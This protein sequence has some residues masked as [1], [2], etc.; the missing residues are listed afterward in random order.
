MLAKIKS[1]FSTPA[2]PLAPYSDGASGALLTCLL[3][4]AGFVDKTATGRIRVG[5]GMATP[6]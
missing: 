5:R 3:L 6:G 2:W 1:L 4:L